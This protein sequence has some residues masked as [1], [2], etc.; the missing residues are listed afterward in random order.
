MKKNISF[1]VLALSLCCSAGAQNFNAGPVHVNGAVYDASATNGS[2]LTT[3]SGLLVGSGGTW[4][5]NNAQL[6][7]PR[8]N[9]AQTEVVKFAGG[10]YNRTSGYINGYAA[11]ENQLSGF[12]LP[13]GHS[14][15]MP[16]TINSSLASG[17][18][19]TAAWYDNQQS[20]TTHIA[21]VLYYFLPGY[22]DLR[23]TDAGVSVTASVPADAQAGTRLT[24]TV[25]GINYV[26]LGPANTAT[27][28]PSGT[29]QLRFANSSAVLPLTLTAFTATKQ[30]TT[31][32]L[33]WK[34]SSEQNIHSYTVERS[35]DSRTFN[36]VGSVTSLGNTHQDRTY[37]LYD[38]AP[39]NGANY[40]RLKIAEK[41]GRTSYSPVRQ[42]SFD[43]AIRI[44]AYPNPVLDKAF[45][46]GLEKGMQ[47]TLL[48]LQ[49]QPLVSQK[50]SG[51]TLT[52]SMQHLPAAVYQ[53]QVQ[54][55]TGK[56][57]GSYRIAKE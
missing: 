22:Y 9:A 15:Y 25:D 55:E 30:G 28:L 16:L 52:I 46:T 12:V 37:K 10:T 29:Y 20:P 54:D 14:S 57:I 13:I 17:S 47:V 23:T 32:L 34:I 35:A 45:I 5:L 31:S 53:V 26:D 56:L 24:G 27:T 48:N 44:S 19:V 21:G 36:Q 8:N 3:N 51:N 39:L 6:I 4:L 50:A 41:D 49:G 18:M 11:A 40:Y 1:P 42:L 38:P 43:A 7:T 2:M 33:S